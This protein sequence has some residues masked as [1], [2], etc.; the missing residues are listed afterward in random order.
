MTPRRRAS[1]DGFTLIEVIMA[2]TIAATAM[3]MLATLATSTGRRGY[4]N[5]MATKRNFALAQQASRI[6]VM[7]FDLVT[8]LTSG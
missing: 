5:D 1:R 3:I 6:Q 2:M 7:P 8:Q 4:T